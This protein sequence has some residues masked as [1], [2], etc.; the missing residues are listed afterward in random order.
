MD[1]V[2]LVRQLTEKAIEHHEKQFLIFVDLH[3]AY[4][5]VPCEAL[6]MALEKLGV[7]TVLI[8]IVKSFHAD[9]RARVKLTQSY[10]GRFMFLMA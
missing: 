3:K 2:F 9:M 10:Q 6:W 5:S 8:D 4:D 1:R 7:P